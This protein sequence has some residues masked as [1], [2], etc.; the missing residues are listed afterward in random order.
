MGIF[1]FVEKLFYFRVI[2]CF[3]IETS[4][5]IQGNMCQGQS[6]CQKFS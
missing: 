6:D 2:A 1:I 4:I 3:S 5:N